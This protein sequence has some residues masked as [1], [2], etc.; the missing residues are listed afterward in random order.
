MSSARL[1]ADTTPLRAPDFRRPSRV[2][3]GGV[4]VVVGVLVAPAVAPAF[5][6]CRM[7]PV[8]P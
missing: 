4:L 3:A 2:S 1:F 5:V 6:R 8:K 7:G